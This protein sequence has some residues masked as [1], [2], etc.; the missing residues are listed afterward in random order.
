MAAGL[1]E[2]GGVDTLLSSVEVDDDCNALFGEEVAKS[3][4]RQPFK[5][6]DIYSLFSFW[7]ARDFL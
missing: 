1:G 6:L 4:T 5:D 7:V 2:F 3:T